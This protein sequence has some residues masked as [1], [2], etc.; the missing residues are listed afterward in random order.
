MLS[1][2]TAAKLTSNENES[3]SNLSPGPDD[4]CFH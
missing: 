1:L 3:L 4:G 2:I